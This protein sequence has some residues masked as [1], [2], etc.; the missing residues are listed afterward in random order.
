MRSIPVKDGV[1]IFEEDKDK[2]LK[3]IFKWLVI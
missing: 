3:V 1:I 2:T